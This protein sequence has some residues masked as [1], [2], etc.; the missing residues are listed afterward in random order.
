MNFLHKALGV[1]F[2]G[3]LFPVSK[4]GR[5]SLPVPGA[6]NFDYKRLNPPSERQFREAARATPAM[7]EGSVG[8]SSYSKVKVSGAKNFD[9]KRLNPPNERQFREAAS[10]AYK[11]TGNKT[12]TYVG[13]A[14][15][16]GVDLTRSSGYRRPKAGNLF[17]KSYTESIKDVAS[18]GEKVAAEAGAAGWHIPKPGLLATGITAGLAGYYAGDQDASSFGLGA[19]GGFAGG[20]AAEIAGGWMANHLES[21]GKPMSE[22]GQKALAIGEH[23]TS[24]G[25]RGALFAAGALLGGGMFASMFSSGRKSYKSGFN[26]NRGNSF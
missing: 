18:T 20:R 12:A 14:D 24:R 22:V 3:E 8:R 9:Y 21:V 15:G 16:V 13:T 26:Q 5:P 2:G 1:D 19:V 11:P 4:P 25:G 10:G 23:L 17:E 7:V 6:K